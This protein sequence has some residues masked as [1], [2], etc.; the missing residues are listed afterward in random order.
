MARIQNSICRLCFD[1]DE[2]TQEE[3]ARRVGCTLQ[4]II[5]LEQ[6]KYVPSLELA[7]KIA[8]VFRVGLKR[9]FSI[10]GGVR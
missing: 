10:T 1:H 5:A 3:L 6:G 8:R 2:M 4:T 7:F 9:G